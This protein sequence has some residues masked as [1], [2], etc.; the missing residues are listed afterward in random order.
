MF[1]EQRNKVEF[2]VTLRPVAPSHPFKN[3]IAFAI[4]A[5]VLEEIAWTHGPAHV[6]K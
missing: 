3:R 4:R 2:T 5:T 6:E 1:G